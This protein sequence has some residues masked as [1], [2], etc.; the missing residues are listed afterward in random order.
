V[1]STS[2]RANPTYKPD[3]IIHDNGKGAYTLVH[4]A[5]AGDRNVIRNKQRS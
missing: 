3:I 4:V 2:A 5:V 1:E